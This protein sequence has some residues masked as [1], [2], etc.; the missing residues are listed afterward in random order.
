MND[1]VLCVRTNIIGKEARTMKA[2]EAVAKMLSQFQ[3]PAEESAPLRTVCHLMVS[4]AEVR[5]LGRG[6]ADLCTGRCQGCPVW[7]ERFYGRSQR[8]LFGDRL[9]G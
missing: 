3:K 5:D 7:L 9:V 2:E 4:T 8:N 6:L 1:E